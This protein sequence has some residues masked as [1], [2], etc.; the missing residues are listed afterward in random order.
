MHESTPTPESDELIRAI[1]LHL[2]ESPFVLK[3]AVS[4]G[5][6]SERVLERIKDEAELRTLG[7]QQREERL[8]KALYTLRSVGL[9]RD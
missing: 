2:A 4:S 8:Q 9:L 6:R 5:E 7:A 3:R 1:E